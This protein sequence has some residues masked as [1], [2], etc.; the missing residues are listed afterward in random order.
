MTALGLLSVLDGVAHVDNAG[1][2]SYLAQIARPSRM[3]EALITLAVIAA[4]LLVLQ[5]SRRAIQ[6]TLLTAAAALAVAVGYV[7]QTHYIDQRYLGRD[8]ALDAVLEDP[9]THTVA[10]T[11]S[12]DPGVTPVALPLNGP[13]L[14]NRVRVLGRP[15]RHVLFPLRN[16]GD[17][18]AALRGEP[19]DVLFVQRLADGRPSA[20]ARWAEELG[21]RP[22]VTGKNSI[23]F[24]R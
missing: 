20:T 11:G 2:A 6:L 3:V 15:L 7:H 16:R 13:R 5:R 8:P 22:A 21:W 12:T 19:Y 1:G 24:R 17:L 4:A 10:L 9:G 18:A 23:L 14:E